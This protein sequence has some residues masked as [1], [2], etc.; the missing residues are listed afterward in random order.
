MLQGVESDHLNRVTEL[1]RQKIGN[2]RLDVSALGLPSGAMRPWTFHDQI[3][4]LIGAIRHNWRK[5]AHCPISIS[6]GDSMTARAIGSR[7]AFQKRPPDG[8][9]ERACRRR[10]LPRVVARQG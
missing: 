2:N 8:A 1:S 6:N 5:S 7:D 3:Y 9:D 4:C 10:K